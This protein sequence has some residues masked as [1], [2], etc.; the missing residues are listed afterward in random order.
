MTTEKL[1][2]HWINGEWVDSNP[3]RI[4]KFVVEICGQTGLELC[5]KW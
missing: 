1:A 4:R 2:M 3:H 5:S